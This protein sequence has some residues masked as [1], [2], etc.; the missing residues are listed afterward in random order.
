[1]PT[2]SSTATRRSSVSEQNPMT[3]PALQQMADLTEQSANL[4]REVEVVQQ[5]QQHAVQR[6]ALKLQQAAEQLRHSTS[7]AEM[8]SVQSTLMLGGIQ[9]TV[10]YMQEM[11]V[12]MLRMQMALM[13]KQPN[14]HAPEAPAAPLF[15]SPSSSPLSA[16]STAQDA[17]AAATAAVFQSWS[18]MLGAGLNHSNGGAAH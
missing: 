13:P 7:R 14:G 12:T 15:D 5:I 3:I 18:S 8:L 4:F 16:V 1:M 17:A 9:E 6:A 11:A 10:Q 2:K